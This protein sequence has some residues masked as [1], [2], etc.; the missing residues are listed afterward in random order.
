MMH[1]ARQH[2]YPCHSVLFKSSNE[3]YVTRLCLDGYAHAIHISAVFALDLQRNAFMQSLVSFSALLSGD[4]KLDGKK[5]DLLLPPSRAVGAE[6]TFSHE[7][8]GMYQDAP[9]RSEYAQQ[10]FEHIVVSGTRAWSLRC[11]I[12]A[13]NLIKSHTYRADSETDIAT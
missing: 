7:T 2:V 10:L 4:F 13:Q 6:L 12:T 1:T 5:V 11:G 3:L 9:A 8:D